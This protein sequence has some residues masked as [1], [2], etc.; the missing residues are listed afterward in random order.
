ML[1][2]MRGGMGRRRSIAAP[3]GSVSR[4]KLLAAL[5][6]AALAGGLIGGVA[7][8]DGPTTARTPV[9]QQATAAGRAR[10][11]DGRAMAGKRR[12]PKTRQPVAPPPRAVRPHGPH[13]AATALS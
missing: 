2:V 1:T 7:M 11:F 6:S 9:H 5:A 10:N 12:G 3:E 8:L 4:K 13:A